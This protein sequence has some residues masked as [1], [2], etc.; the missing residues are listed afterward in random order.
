[1]AAKRE[2]GP[3]RT[4][5]PYAD[6]RYGPRHGTS[7]RFVVIGDSG[8]ASLGADLPEQTMGAIIATGLAGGLRTRCRAGEHGRRRRSQQRP[9]P[10][11][12]AGSR[13]CR[14]HV[15]L[16]VIGAND[17]THLRGTQRPCRELGAAVA[18]LREH[19]SEVVVGTCPD[20]GT[21]TPLA[22]PLRTVA[23]RLSRQMAAAQTVAVVAA[24]GRSVSLADL[25]GPE[26][27]ARP[28]EMFAADRFHPSAAGYAVLAAAVMPSVLSALGLATEPGSDAGAARALLP[29]RAAA[30]QAVERGGTE[31]A[32]LPLAGAVR[33]R[34]RRAAAAVVQLRRR[35]RMPLPH[36]DA[37]DSDGD[38]HGHPR[39]PDG[40]GTGTSGTV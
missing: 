34:G 40:T 29:V 4:V 15:V 33:A 14:P 30:V 11:G 17:I 10:A 27:E 2:I 16:V 24:G 28:E 26:F 39:L 9:R 20:L 32:G 22:Q 37:P 1:M 18:R 5:P 23:R 7:L 36:V 19:G 25:L 35:I 31:V 21:V 38:R 8:A 13:C 3:R 12:G 6:G